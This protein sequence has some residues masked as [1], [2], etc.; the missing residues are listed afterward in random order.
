MRQ[1]RVFIFPSYYE[2]FGI[3]VREAMICGLPVVAYD[4]PILLVHEEGIV[5]VH[6]FD[7]RKFAEEVYRLLVDKEYYRE[8]SAEAVEYASR[9]TWEKTGEEVYDIITSLEQ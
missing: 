3:V 5:N 7:N 4:L 1:A 6:L 2:S 8:M 9:H